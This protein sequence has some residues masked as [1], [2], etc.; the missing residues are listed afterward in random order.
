MNNN[1]LQ[2]YGMTAYNSDPTFSNMGYATNDS[3][4]YQSMTPPSNVNTNSSKIGANA[5][6]QSV[7]NLTTPPPDPA[8]TINMSEMYP[9][10]VTPTLTGGIQSTEQA[11]DMSMSA[12]RMSPTEEA[13]QASLKNPDMALSRLRASDNENLGKLGLG[14]RLS[15]IG[16]KAK[17]IGSKAMGTIEKYSGPATVAMS[18]VG[19]IS[20]MNAASRAVDSLKGGIS[21]LESVV[22]NLANEEDAQQKAMLD[23]FTEQRRQIGQK[24][25][26]ALGQTLN[27]VKGSNINTGSIKKIK[28]DITDKYRTSSDLSLINAEDNYSSQVDQYAQECRKKRTGFNNQLVSLR[29]QLAQAEKAASPTQ[30]FLDVTQAA[31]SVAN[32]AAGVAIALARQNIG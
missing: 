15:G 22:G 19:A 31:V 7:Q 8:S 12:G 24:Q 2:K 4:S 14:E 11:Y 16:S 1:I 17:E 25:N 32:P 20:K 18:A 23:G 27:S 21:D 28:E 6:Q 3:N 30:A 26:L 13:Y 5:Q 10:K 29:N 9:D